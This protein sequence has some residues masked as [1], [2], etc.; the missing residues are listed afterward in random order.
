MPPSKVSVLPSSRAVSA[1]RSSSATSENSVP[2]GERPSPSRTGDVL[3]AMD[4][5]CDTPSV[6]S[7]L[8]H[9]QSRSTSSDSVDPES[10]GRPADRPLSQGRTASDC[11]EG[12]GSALLSTTPGLR[13]K[14]SLPSI[15][16]SKL[17]T[18]RA[19][20][21]GLSGS[22]RITV[23]GQVSKSE[24]GSLSGARLSRPSK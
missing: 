1:D 21:S 12:A 4:I 18:P 19:G 17:V 16:P 22:R 24:G 7:P 6:A 11:A 9:Q 2:A 14:S 8:I 23:P 10:R 20:P 13:R 5:P 15:P 3:V